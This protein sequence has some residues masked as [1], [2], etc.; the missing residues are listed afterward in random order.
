[1]NVVVLA[2]VQGNRYPKP[3]EISCRIFQFVLGDLC[4]W[5]FLLCW[6]GLLLPNNRSLLDPESEIFFLHAYLRG[7][8]YGIRVPCHCFDGPWNSRL[9]PCTQLQQK[10]E[11]D[12]H[13]QVWFLRLT[14]VAAQ[15]GNSP[16]G[17]HYSVRFWKGEHQTKFTSSTFSWSPLWV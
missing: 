3:L 8:L 9:T 13:H 15:A 14:E 7:L 2:N 11:E 4:S 5:M 12:H 1:M 17:Q 6:A 16:W 10:K